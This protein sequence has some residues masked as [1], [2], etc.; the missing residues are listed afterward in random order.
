MPRYVNFI[1]ALMLAGL[2]VIVPQVFAQA[3][4]IV[5]I[6][7]DLSSVHRSAS[8]TLT[9]N[10][11]TPSVIQIRGYSWIQQGN[12]DT[13]VSTNKLSVSPPFATIPA[14]KSQTV[15]V[16]LREPAAKG[17]EAYR[18]IFDQI[19]ERGV[20]KVQLAIRF[21]VPVFSL[22]TQPASPDVQ[23]RIERQGEGMMLVAVNQGLKHS[24]LSNL[25]ATTVSG[26]RLKLTGPGMPY[27]LAGNQQH[28]LISDP[29]HLL[30]TGSRIHVQNANTQNKSDQWVNVGPGH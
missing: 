17:E 6:R 22:S 3:L 21:T 20:A 27:I 2:W 10:A 14:G 26:E 15:R 9:N 5:P 11:D 4:A 1:R 19:P 16:L 24:M 23:W 28:W 29:R 12:N 25:S 7:Q 8:F 13:F 18:I 30:T